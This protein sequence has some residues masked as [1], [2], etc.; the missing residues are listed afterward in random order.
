MQYSTPTRR[1]SLW[2]FSDRL[3]DTNEYQTGVK[4]SDQQMQKLQIR[5]HEVHGQWN[6]TI[7]PRFDTPMPG[8]DPTKSPER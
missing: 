6:Y 3:L 7:A 5:P 8:S 2:E 4:I 1:T